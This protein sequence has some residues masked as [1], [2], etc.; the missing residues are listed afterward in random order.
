MLSTVLLLAIG[1]M[2]GAVIALLWVATMK[3]RYTQQVR[4]TAVEQS[5]AV[6]RGQIYE[7]LVPYLPEF[8]F[9]PKDAQFLGKPVDFVVFDGLDEGD[10]RRIVFVE[11]KTGVATLTTRERRVRDAIREGRVEWTEIRMPAPLVAVTSPRHL[12]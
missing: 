9:N 1:V 7:Q 6:T 11:V 3:P 10:L 8:E 12:S 4:R 5:K 2:T